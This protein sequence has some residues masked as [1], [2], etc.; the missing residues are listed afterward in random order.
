[1]YNNA[2]CLPGSVQYVLWWELPAPGLVHRHQAR[3]RNLLPT[4]V[5]P[6]AILPAL[7]TTKYPR[8]TTLG[9][10]L[11]VC[12]VPFVLLCVFGILLISLV[13]DICG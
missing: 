3:Q 8:Y 13:T 2:L 4:H 9:Y 1:M 11:L 7:E 10:I 6:Q 5:L 12:F